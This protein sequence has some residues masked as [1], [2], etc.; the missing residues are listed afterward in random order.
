MIGRAAQGQPWLCGQIAT[1]LE[2]GCTP[3]APSQTEQLAILGRHVS[4]LH[5]FY[6]EFMGLRIARK[7]VSWFLQRRNGSQSVRALFNQ[8]ADHQEQLDFIS[9]LDFIDSNKELAA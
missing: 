4:D 5:A 1:Y 6:G 2:T 8:I 9:H 3:S 7:H